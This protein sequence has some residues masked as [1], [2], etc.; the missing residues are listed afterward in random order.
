MNRR[1]IAVTVVAWVYVAAG[2][3]SIVHHASELKATSPFDGGPIGRCLIGLLAVVGGAFMLRG[4]NW[5]RWLSILWLFGHVVLSAFHP[6]PELIMHT[7]L[8]VGFTLMLFQPCASA[9]FCGGKAGIAATKQSNQ[10]P[11]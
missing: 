6:L 9:Y 7:V 4:W 5:A 2:I 11:P 1:P 3:L 8:L 10:D